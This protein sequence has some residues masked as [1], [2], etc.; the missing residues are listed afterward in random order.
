ML[1]LLAQKKTTSGID[2]KDSR[3]KRS[4]KTFYIQFNPFSSIKLN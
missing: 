4:S 2:F 1:D 3:Q